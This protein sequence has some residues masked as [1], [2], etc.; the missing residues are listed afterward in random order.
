MK[1]YKEFNES[2]NE[3]VVSEFKEL[4]N[5]SEYRKAVNIMLRGWGDGEKSITKNQKLDIKIFLKG[6][7][8]SKQDEYN[9][10]Y[11]GAIGTFG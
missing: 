5:N 10:I 9:K 11:R 2:L 7:D 8:D 6:S 3:D 1:N 4:Y